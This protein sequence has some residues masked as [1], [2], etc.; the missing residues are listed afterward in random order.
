MDNRIKIK[1]K[2]AYYEFI[3]S[4][5]FIAGIQLKGTEIKSLRQGKANLTDS[6]CHFTDGELFV[7]KMHIAEYTFGTH[8]NHEPKRERK[9]LL[10]KREL[11]R[12]LTKVKEKGFTIVPTFLFINNKGLAKLEIALAKGKNVHDKRES[13]KD[14]DLKRDLDR[15]NYL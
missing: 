13:I 4:E 11:K 5:K 9:L 1:N 7:M 10:N 15:R 6:Y 2:K 14:K 8:Y 12:L 3:I